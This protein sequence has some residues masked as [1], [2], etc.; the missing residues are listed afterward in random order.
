MACQSVQDDG[1]GYSSLM[2]AIADLPRNTMLIRRGLYSWDVTGWTI[3][4]TGGALYQ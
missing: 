4:S 2:E 3:T 1:Q